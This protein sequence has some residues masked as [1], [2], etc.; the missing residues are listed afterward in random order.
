MSELACLPTQAQLTIYF[1]VH[2]ASSSVGL[3]A[4]SLAKAMG[5]KV[6]GVCSENCFDLV[7]SHGAKEVAS[8]RAGEDKCAEDIKRITG[9]GVLLG[10]DTISEDESTKIVLGGFKKGGDEHKQLNLILPPKEEDHKIRLDVKLVLT[11][12][13]T[14]FGIVRCPLG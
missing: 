9:G 4:V 2:G 14:L 8:Y 7:K 11:M 5:Y 12:M 6:I 3:F 1:L 13:L 10:L